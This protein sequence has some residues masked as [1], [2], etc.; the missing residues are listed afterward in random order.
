MK[1]VIHLQTIL[2]TTEMNLL[3]ITKMKRNERNNVDMFSYQLFNNSHYKNIL[4]LKIKLRIFKNTERL[5][6]NVHIVLSSIT[7]MV[8]ARTAIIQRE[9]LRNQPFVN[10]QTELCMPRVNART[11][12]YLNIT[13]RREQTKI[14]SLVFAVSINAANEYYQITLNTN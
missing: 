13:R 3:F 2:L 4:S 7:Q 9:G 6:Q 10:I 8:C 12:T 5:F 11:V 1:R 14:P